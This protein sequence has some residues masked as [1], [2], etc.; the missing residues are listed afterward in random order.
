MALYVFIR[1]CI[2]MAYDFH[3][4]SWPGNQNYYFFAFK[5]VLL[6]AAQDIKDIML[7]SM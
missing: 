4:L 6:P 5:R 7:R 1:I 3:N 2:A